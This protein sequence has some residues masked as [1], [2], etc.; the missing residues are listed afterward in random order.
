MPRSSAGNLGAYTLAAIAAGSSP[1][2]LM[3]F[4]LLSEVYCRAIWVL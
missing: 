2:H 1:D 3:N 4:R